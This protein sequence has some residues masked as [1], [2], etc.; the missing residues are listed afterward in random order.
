ML[1]IGDKVE[2]N[3]KYYVSDKNKKDIYCIGRTAGGMRTISV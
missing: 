1:K 2:M 3:G